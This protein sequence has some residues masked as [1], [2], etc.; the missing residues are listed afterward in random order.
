[1]IPKIIHYCWFGSNEKIRK[2]K[3]CIESWKKYLPDYEIK[4]WNENNFDLNIC[5]YVKYDAYPKNG[6]TYLITQKHLHYITKG[7]IYLDTDME[8]KEA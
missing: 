4:E 3:K 8:I 7:G 6:L 5:N 1:M 2:K